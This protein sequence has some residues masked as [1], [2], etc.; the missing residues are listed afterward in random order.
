MTLPVTIPNTFANATTSIPLANLD[1]NFVTIYDAVNGIG[2]GA[3][4]LANVSIT[5][6]TVTNVA[7]SAT[8]LNTSGQVVFNDAGAD[9]DFRVEGDTNANLLFVDASTDR[10]G[11]GLNT[12]ETLLHSYSTSANSNLFEYSQ[13]TGLSTVVVPAVVRTTASNLGVGAGTGIDF[14]LRETTT[15]Y[16]GARINTV[17]TSSA[18]D[19]ALAFSTRNTGGTVAEGMRLSSAGEFIVGGSASIA[20]EGAITVQKTNNPAILNLY[21]N[22]TSIVSGNS[23][24]YIQFYGNDTT[25][26]NP[27]LHAY[28]YAMA[29][30]THA[31]GDNPTDLVFGTTLDDTATVAEAGRVSSNGSYIATLN[32]LTNKPT[33]ILGTPGGYPG[34]IMNTD[35]VTKKQY[36]IRLV[37]DS[38]VFAREGLESF[39]VNS[40]LVLCVG[41]IGGLRSAIG[42][43]IFY[44]GGGN[45]I[46]VQTGNTSVTTPVIVFYD[47]GN[48]DCGSIDVNPTANTTAYT[49]SSDYR[50]KDNVQPIFGALEKV[51][52]LKPC[53]WNWK[54]SPETTGEGFIAHEL[55]EICPEAVTG[56]K[57]EMQMQRFEVSPAVYE[58]VIIP[59]EL[60]NDGNIVKP[61]RTEQKLISE[62]V[63]EEREVPAYQGVDT[64][65]LVATLTAA[66]QELKTE[67][68]T[69]KAE[70]ATLKG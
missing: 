20:S 24:G 55:Q 6:G 1:A 13:S 21:R 23:F 60:D 41:S 4:S 44:N 61:E 52:Q 27:T 16:V 8:T 57:D 2:N 10:I 12:P 46:D 54:H 36:D 62:A 43:A 26:N 59:A 40:S 35:E 66:I 45:V 22:D 25:S 48:T 5:G 49:T 31:A 56:T 69:V 3:E 65:F 17:R 18:S 29:S 39:R 37:G 51:A 50:L 30:G 38:M 15:D 63:Y 68:D 58:D 33:V 67:L 32:S 64:S 19:Q 28:I 47:G 42:S 53:T 11:V 70:L 14:T 34:V 9:V 7:V